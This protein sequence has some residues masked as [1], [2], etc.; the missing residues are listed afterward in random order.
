MTAVK[1][2]WR[3]F[4][5]VRMFQLKCKHI[6]GR[7]LAYWEPVI[8]FSYHSPS[9]NCILLC[10]PIVQGRRSGF[11]LEESPKS[12]RIGKMKY[13]GYF[14]HRLAWILQ[15]EHAP[16]DNAPRHQLLYRMSCMRILTKR[17]DIW[18]TDIVVGIK[19]HFP[20]FACSIFSTKRIN[21]IKVL[22]FPA[23]F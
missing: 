3:S 16:T 9:N 23:W 20:S 14:L 4:K 18:A 10:I 12:R 2:L 7:V 1:I 8:N 22:I 6:F 15:Q 19:G 21:W 5:N 11:F 17:K 13:I